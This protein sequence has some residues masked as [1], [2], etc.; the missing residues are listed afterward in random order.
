MK[1]WVR[2][3]FLGAFSLAAFA[4][5]TDSPVVPRSASLMT[6]YGC[7]ITPGCW[8][9]GDPSPGAAGYWMGTFVT[10]G[11]CFSPSGAGINDADRDGMDDS[12]EQYLAQRFT[13]AMSYSP[14]DCNSGGEPYWAAKYFP[15]H[16]NVVRIIYMP[17]YYVDCGTSNQTIS[18]IAASIF[19]DALYVAEGLA[20]VLVGHLPIAPENPCNGHNGD[21]EFVVEEVNYDEDTSHW[22][23]TYAFL[24]AHWT[25]K[26]DASAGV[27]PNA[28]Q[29][30]EVSQGYPLIWVSEGKHANYVSR[31]A[32]NDGHAETCEA[33]PFRGTRLAFD[34]THNIGSIQA[35]LISPRSCV[36]GGPY[37]VQSPDAY[38]VE[39]FWEGGD[40]PSYRFSGWAPAHQ[41]TDAQAYI[42]PL[43]FKFECYSVVVDGSTVSCID[44]GVSR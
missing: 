37:H 43:V 38:G 30:P 23:L 26:T 22:V 2:G 8:S 27:G 44:S 15:N 12:C 14:Y 5:N 29:F 19:E 21:G 17:A 28:L 3:V 35:N 10:P 11:N 7:Q 18:C 9:D 16:G 6:T 24:S 32:C 13:P 39:C 4:C 31:D 36:T 42:V 40:E 41:S 25:D 33:N 1:A 20:G 34:G